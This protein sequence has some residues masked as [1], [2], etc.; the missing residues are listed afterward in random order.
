MKIITKNAVYVQKND[1]SFLTHGDFEIRKYLS[2]DCKYFVIQFKVNEY[3]DKIKE[4]N[5]EQETMSKRLVKKIKTIF[6]K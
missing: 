2:E 5:T 4:E 1:I 6:K 3:D